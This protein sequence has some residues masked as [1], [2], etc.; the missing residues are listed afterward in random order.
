MSVTRK[1]VVFRGR[2]QGVGFRFTAKQVSR[3]HPVVGWVKNMS[4]GTVQMLVEAKPCE[5]SAFVQSVIAAVESQ[6]YGNVESHEL[7]E[8]M[9]ATDEYATFEIRV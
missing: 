1:E 8:S 2:V 7:S 5:I 3:D 9:N 6:G 4:D